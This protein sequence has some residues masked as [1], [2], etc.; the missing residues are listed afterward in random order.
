MSEGAISWGTY[1]LVGSNVLG[2]TNV[3]MRANI[4]VGTNVLGCTNDLGME[5]FPPIFVFRQN[6]YQ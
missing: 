6:D 5:F 2:G 3:L 4:L 1:V